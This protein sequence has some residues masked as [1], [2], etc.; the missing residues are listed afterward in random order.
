MS[1][2]RQTLPQA[3][4]DHWTVSRTLITAAHPSIRVAD[5]AAIIAGLV[6]V[7][8][9]GSAFVGIRAA[10]GTFSP[11][12]L[13][14]GRL[15]VST[16]VLSVVAV[17]S[18][19]RIPQR[20]DLA[21]IA[22]YGLLWLGIYSVALNAAERL[23]DAGTAAML[24]ATGP[25]LIAVLSGLFLNEGFPAGLF[26]GCAVA[27]GGSVLIGLATS[28]S[29]AQHGVGILLCVI[30]ILSY[31]AAIVI[32]KRILGRVTALQLTWLG[33]A[34][35]TLACMPFVPTLLKEM[36]NAHPAAVGWLVYLGA[37]PTAI[38]FLTWTYALRRMTAGRTGSLLYLVPVVAVLLSW[39]I[40]GEVPAGL[41][42]LGGAL[43]LLGVSL[44]RRQRVGGRLGQA[45]L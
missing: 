42:F 9:W 35:A 29:G 17:L 14:I 2:F 37:V 30:A 33:S 12:A 7:C 40:L 45:R 25:I 15:F 36:P 44:A 10:G 3:S 43:C 19:Q 39:A 31:S 28:R 5:P 38:G 1:D 20:R 22:V 24:V 4:A 41:A 21:R 26:V 34:A 27:F 18:H 13:A 16:A 32:Q 23:I 6:T 11:G 8:L